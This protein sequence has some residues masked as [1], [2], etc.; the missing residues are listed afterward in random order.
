[1]ARRP[2]PDHDGFFKKMDVLPDSLELKK[3]TQ[4]LKETLGE[5][6]FVTTWNRG[7]SLTLEQAMHLALEME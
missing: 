1:M 5:T 6:D 7:R 4:R 3:H 2:L